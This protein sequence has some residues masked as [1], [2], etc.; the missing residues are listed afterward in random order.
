MKINVLVYKFPSSTLSYLKLTP[1]WYF[2][3]SNLTNYSYAK[4][5]IFLPLFSLMVQFITSLR[6]DTSRASVSVP[7]IPDI[8][9]YKPQV[10]ISY[11]ACIH[12]LQRVLWLRTSPSGWG[13]FQRCHVLYGSEPRIPAEV[14]SSAATCTMAPDLIFQLRWVPALPRVLS[15][16]PIVWYRIWTCVT[17]DEQRAQ[18]VHVVKEKMN[19]IVTSPD[20]I[21][22]I[23]YLYHQVA[24]SFPKA[25][26]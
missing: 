13:G 11:R 18:N 22:L 10:K 24:T 21:G 1:W 15:L 25:H 23:A 9:T 12:T 3:L 26:L 19:L 20:L 17:R 5:D 8:L 2:N 4:F 16:H 7:Y 6:I 14:G